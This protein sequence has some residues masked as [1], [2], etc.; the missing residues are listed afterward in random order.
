MSGHI[1]NWEY[2]GPSLGLNKIKCAGVALIQRN[3]TS[4]KFFNDSRKSK[5]VKIIPLDA[6]SNVM[7]QS[8]KDSNYLGLI[9]DS[10]NHF[11]INKPKGEFVIM[12]AKENYKLN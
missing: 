3:S 5:N 2:I 11:E 6:G 8:I 4:N 12:V 9:S 1:G 7:V 10:I